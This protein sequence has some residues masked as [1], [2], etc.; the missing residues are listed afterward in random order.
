MRVLHLCWPALIVI[1]LCTAMPAL[2][3]TGLR[4]ATWNIQHLREEDP[5]RDTDDYA[6]LARYAQL[7]DADVIALQEVE[8]PL[9]LRK[10][11]GDGYDF[12]LSSRHHPQR[13]GFAI[14]K[15][16]R[17][18]AAPTEMRSLAL[19]GQSL[20]Y[21]MDVTLATDM[22]PLRLLAVHLKSFCFDAPLDSDKKACKRLKAQAIPLE[23]WIDTRARSGEAFIVLGDF[24]RRFGKEG[25]DR[26][27]AWLWPILNDGDPVTQSLVRVTQFRSSACWG[28]KYPAFIDHIVL[29]QRAA[30]WVAPDS[31]R[32]IVF[33]G[34]YSRNK[35][36][37][38]HCPIS[39]DLRIPSPPS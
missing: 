26:D 19:D 39:V 11:F 10:I 34:P 35:A 37:S 36:L 23:K 18:I 31:F 22:G 28:G 20:R 2:S 21:G 15:T 25:A 13:T 38:D 16:V 3:D 30:Q 14:R 12:Y 7:L 4:V 6:A 29:D 32:Q 17:L 33:D 8:G 27:G 5:N 1:C 9:A 24:N